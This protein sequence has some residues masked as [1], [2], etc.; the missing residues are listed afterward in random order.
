[1]GWS[2]C[3]WPGASNGLVERQE[4]VGVIHEGSFAPWIHAAL[5]QRSLSCAGSKLM[6]LGTGWRFRGLQT[7]NPA[8][9]STNDID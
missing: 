2:E 7:P 8:S 6:A 4:A 1:M 9:N 5:S 3:Q